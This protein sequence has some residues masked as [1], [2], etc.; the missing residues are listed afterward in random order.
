MSDRG[1]NHPVIP[2]GIYWEM[3]KKN[4]PYRGFVHYND[5]TLTFVLPETVVV[6]L[7]TTVAM[8]HYTRYVMKPQVKYIER[9]ITGIKVV[10]DKIRFDNSTEEIKMD[11]RMTQGIFNLSVN[12]MLIRAF[13]RHFQYQEYNRIKN[14]INSIQKLTLK[15]PDDINVEKSHCQ[16]EFER[17][18][19]KIIDGSLTINDIY[20]NN[21][22]LIRKELGYYFYIQH[23]KENPHLN[24]R[25]KDYTG[26]FSFLINVGLTHGKLKMYN[27]QT[28]FSVQKMK[29]Y[30]K[31]FYGNQYM[32]KRMVA[33]GKTQALQYSKIFGRLNAVLTSVGV[34]ESGVQ[35]YNHEI[36]WTQFSADALS[37]AIG[38][39]LTGYYGVTWGLGW[40]IGRSISQ[41]DWYCDFKE[42]YWYNYRFDTF[43]Y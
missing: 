39:R 43:G 21:Y 42:N 7:Q 20:I 6:K 8:G 16:R 12:R 30:K 27:E 28:W 33:A 36:N 41:T 40:E 25:H 26:I 4:Q 18:K 38:Y 31:G 1:Q 17:L 29:S 22:P 24:P 32:N 15:S 3:V 5:G 11:E 2:E 37:A 19:C 9:P 23:I 14:D 10:N 34:I 35:L 13:E